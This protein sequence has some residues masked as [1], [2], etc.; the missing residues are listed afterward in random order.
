M[1]CFFVIFN[2]FI[3]FGVLIVCIVFEDGDT[4]KK[5]YGLV[6]KYGVGEDVFIGISIIDLYVK[7]GDMNEVVKNFLRILDYNVVL[8]IVMIFGY[9]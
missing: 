9:V 2:S 6:I 7:C 8:W 5:V 1:C 3:F 4:G